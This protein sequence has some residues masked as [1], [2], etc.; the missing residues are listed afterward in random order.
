M[1]DFFKSVIE[2]EDAIDDEGG[3]IKDRIALLEEE[4]TRLKNNDV[5]FYRQRKYCKFS[6][7]Y[8]CTFTGECTHKEKVEGYVSIFGIRCFAED[9]A[10]NEVKEK[11]L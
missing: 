4:I 6:D 10:R 3:K 2:E 8:S 1:N 7:G 11:K 5:F 9:H